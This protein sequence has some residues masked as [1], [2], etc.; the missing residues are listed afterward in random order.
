MQQRK[1][2]GTG[3]PKGA[4]H[5]RRHIPLGVDRFG[6]ACRSDTE[7]KSIAAIRTAK[8]PPRF[9]QSGTGSISYV[10]AN[11]IEKTLDLKIKN[12]TGFKSGRDTDL[13][14]ERGE[15]DCRA[16]SDITVIRAPWN[17]WVLRYLRP[18][19][20][21]GKES[22]AAAGTDGRRTRPARG[23]TLSHA[24]ERH[25]GVYRIRPCKFYATASSAC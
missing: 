24:H 12:V 4:T 19:A 15:I 21:T 25:A 1:S 10:F 9:G 23:E 20:G 22:A 2:A 17:R 5:R 8:T 11:L 18:P 3:R 7:Y 13:G 6:P 16:T 14:L